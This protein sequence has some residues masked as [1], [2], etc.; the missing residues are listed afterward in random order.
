MEELL[1]IQ[2]ARFGDLLQIRRLLKSLASSKRV[3]LCADSALQTLAKL[4]YPDAVF[5]PVQFHGK[6]DARGFLNNAAVFDELK[7][8]NFAQIINCN[9]SRLT[10]AVT[11][12]FEEKRIS[13]YKPA[14]V[15]DGGELASPWARLAFRLTSLRQASPLN[16]V[17][18]WAWFDERPVAPQA[19]NPVARPG[20]RGLGIAIAG[21]EKRRSLRPEILAAIAKTAFQILGNPE[22]RLFGTEAEKAA[23]RKLQ[24]LFSGAMQAKTV[25]LCGKT[26]WPE[27]V[28]EMSN[29]DLL[30]T[31]DTG[32]MHLAAF[33][34]VPV[35]AFFLSSAWCHETGPYGEGHLIFQSISKCSP[36]LESEGC[37]HNLECHLPF[38]LP[39]F[40]RL[41]ARALSGA[42]NLDPVP[43]MQLWK[44]GFDAF[45]A[46]PELL[47][48]NDP[49]AEARIAARQ[50]IAE[51]VGIEEAFAPVSETYKNLLERFDPFSEWVLPPWRYC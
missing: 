24:H 41:F 17:D 7:R 14:H 25:D 47:A 22:I 23:S 6:L 21:R 40:Q 45:G 33:L 2:A 10:C 4:L 26:G 28:S 19:V 5:H 35:A 39:D 20:G 9:F 3:H 13:G 49:F 43:G 32:L 38:D 46:R 31:P 36:C 48:G 50:I 44:S 34:G 30:L 37:S 11:R 8:L 51:R 15:S 27:L 1:V 18:F 42:A 16:L 29:L 12:L